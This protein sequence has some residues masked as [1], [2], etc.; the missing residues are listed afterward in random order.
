MAWPKG[1]KRERKTPGSGRK[2]GT[3]NAAGTVRAA[4]LMAFRAAGGQKYLVRIA[5]EQPAVFC[6]LLGKVLQHELAAGGGAGGSDRY[7]LVLRWVTPEIAA[8]RGWLENELKG[9]DG[10]G[11]AATGAGHGGSVASGE[12]EEI[13]H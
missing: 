3:G 7:E 5:R 12:E 4:V 6:M 8:A 13:I 9:G 1:K 11:P 10:E 2:P